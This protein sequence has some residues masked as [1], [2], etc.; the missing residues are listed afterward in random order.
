MTDIDLIQNQTVDISFFVTDEDNDPLDLG[1]YNVVFTSQ[2]GPQKE[3]G[4]GVTVVDAAGGE[5]N[6]RIDE[7]TS[8]AGVFRYELWFVND[9][10]TPLIRGCLNV[11]RSLYEG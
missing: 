7:E 4:S 5:F 1:P 11:E 6:V 2:A 10:N 8:D 9:D 3:E